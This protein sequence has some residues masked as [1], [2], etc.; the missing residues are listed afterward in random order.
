MSDEN[1]RNP[2]DEVSRRTFLR[3][4]ALVG[5]GAPLAGALGGS[6]AGAQ[7]VPRLSEGAIELEEAT[8]AEMQDRMTNG[9]LTSQELVNRYLERIQT[10]DQ[11][12]PSV[13]SILEVNPEA[14]KIAKNRDKERKDHGPRGPLH[15]IP[16]VLKG[17]IDTAD[18][19]TTTAGSLALLGDPPHQDATVAARLRAAGAVILGKANLSEWANFRGFNSSSGWS[20]QGGQ[21]RNPY[22]LDRNPCG[23]S[24][25]SAAA[26]S[27]NF[28][29]GAL[30]TETD[31]SI[32]CPASANG[33]VGIKT[34]VGLTSRA[35][36]I[37]ISHTQD[38]VGPHGRTVAD[39][40][41]ILSALVGVD[42]RDPATGASTGRFST[43]YREFLDP[44]AL[45]G[46]RIGVMRGG[47]F[48][49]YSNE[50]D[51]LYEE[52]LAAM[53]DAGAVLVDAEIPTIDELNADLAEI[54][55]LV[56]E[57]KRDLNA[58]LAT[59]TGVPVQD[60]ADVIAFNLA[61]ANQ[62]LQYFGQE[63]FELAEAEIFT[64]AEY[65]L[66]LERGHRLAGPEGIDAIIAEKDLD[67]LVAPTGSPAW[68]TDLVN[69]DHFLGASSGPAAVAGYPNISVPMG[70]SFGLPVGI[71]FMAGAWTEGQLIAL[72]SSFEAATHVR[73]APAFEPTLPLP[74]PKPS[75]RKAAEAAAVRAQKLFDRLKRNPRVSRSL[76]RLI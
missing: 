61:H 5:A 18:Q 64:E 72:T 56:Y 46:A 43:D 41:T 24:S 23:S 29:A 37:P 70:F 66:A 38:T 26:V 52:A 6:E 71:S 7:T 53:A 73:R 47:G 20:G 51:E 45:Q 8:I 15:G 55:V 11:N 36:V 54:I 35:G 16:I 62:E 13:N 76:L 9:G 28:A 31:G 59:R 39:A 21:T 74:N 12:G 2:L 1:G 69:G 4:G 57:F 75:D 63:W 33:V 22:I 58:Y 60:M 25:G 40:A 17:N 32:V 49:G 19:M 27:A 44:D 68:T 3:L 67:A 30:G 50:T 65:I 48:T 10:L 34:T 42:P 14:K